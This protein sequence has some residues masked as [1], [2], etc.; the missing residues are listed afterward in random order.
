MGRSG[1][2][3]EDLS[4]ARSLCRICGGED[5]RNTKST[6][7]TRPLASK[8]C[9]K[10]SLTRGAMWRPTISEGRIANALCDLGSVLPRANIVSVST[11]L[12]SR[13]RSSSPILKILATE[14]A[15]ALASF[16]LWSICRCCICCCCC[17][18]CGC[19]FS[20]ST[21][22]GSEPFPSLIK[23]AERNVTVWSVV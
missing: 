21:N 1:R 18:C 14:S 8:S 6:G 9:S 11:R 13:C 17:I 3:A 12:H 5:A 10:S 7:V 22:L 19:Y 15:A 20:L 23:K 16:A 4:K 2:C